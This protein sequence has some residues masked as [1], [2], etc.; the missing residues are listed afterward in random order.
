MA[1][2]CYLSI[3]DNSHAIYLCL[4]VYLTACCDT[5]NTYVEVVANTSQRQP[6]FTL[7]LNQLH[8]SRTQI[9]FSI[10]SGRLSQIRCP[11]SGRIAQGATR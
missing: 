9:P 8:G 1:G 4:T 3:P 7:A 6:D 5:N 11:H 10:I 2:V